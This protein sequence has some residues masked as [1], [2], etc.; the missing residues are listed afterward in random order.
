MSTEKVTLYFKLYSYKCQ[1][2]RPYWNHALPLVVVNNVISSSDCLQK[3]EG[4]PCVKGTHGFMS[5]IDR[6]FQGNNLTEYAIMHDMS[7]VNNLIQHDPKRMLT[8]VKDNVTL[9]TNLFN[10]FNF[11]QFCATRNHYP[12]TLNEL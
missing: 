1:A 5:V 7:S 9:H 3:A 8:Y 11:H 6:V 4:E 10:C 12:P 2:L